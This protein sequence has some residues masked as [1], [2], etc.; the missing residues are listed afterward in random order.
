MKTL[1]NAQQIVKKALIDEIVKNSSKGMSKY[2]RSL[3]KPTLVY[4][5]TNVL[6]S[7][8]DWNKSSRADLSDLIGREVCEVINE[9]Y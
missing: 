7:H 4:I 2:L 3:D 8:L 9:N 6:G 1:Q 5:A